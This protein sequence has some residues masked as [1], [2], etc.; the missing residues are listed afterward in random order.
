MVI[1]ARMNDEDLD[2]LFRRKL[3]LKSI[4][5]SPYL[6]EWLKPNYTQGEV[7]VGFYMVHRYWANILGSYASDAGR[8]VTYDYYY[9]PYHAYYK[10][11]LLFNL[12]MY[13]FEV[14]YYAYRWLIEIGKY[15]Y[16]PINDAFTHA[17]K[18]GGKKI[19]LTPTKSLYTVVPTPASTLI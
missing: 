11:S 16:L 12:E 19:G 5:L 18:L 1:L 9:P 3:P 2:T 15:I 6:F 10:S 8:A 7:P 14:K 17:F 4:E 13:A